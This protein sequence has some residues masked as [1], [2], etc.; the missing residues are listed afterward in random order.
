MRKR[1]YTI[2][3]RANKQEI[4]IIRQKAQQ[5]GYCFSEYVRLSALGCVPIITAEDNYEKAGKYDLPLWRYEQKRQKAS[6]A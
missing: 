1:D 3:V 4:D 2:R 6:P 5:S